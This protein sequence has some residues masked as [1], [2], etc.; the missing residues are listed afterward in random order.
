MDEYC[1]ECICRRRSRAP[2]G[3]PRGARWSEIAANRAVT[4]DDHDAGVR[5]HSAR[6]R[7]GGAAFQ[8]VERGAGLAVDQQRAA[9][10]AAP[11]REVIDPRR[12]VPAAVA[13]AEL[14]G[15]RGGLLSGRRHDRPARAQCPAARRPAAGFFRA[16]REVRPGT[17]S[18]NVFRL[19]SAQAQNKRRTV[20]RITTRRPPIVESASRI[21]QRRC[22]QSETARHAGRQP[23]RSWTWRA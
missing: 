18:V 23:H 10:L 22:T 9:V 13:P 16:K 2:R 21:A 4:A 11:E 3:G 20:S 6:E 17:C 15:C 12:G 14:P 7:L 5:R 8:Q 1:I 19:Q